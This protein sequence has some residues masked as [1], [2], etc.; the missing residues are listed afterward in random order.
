MKK[1]IH[2]SIKNEDGICGLAR[3]PMKVQ[4]TG[5]QEEEEETGM[6]YRPGNY[7]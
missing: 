1:K 7:Y 2:A 3:N 4:E 6:N 5:V